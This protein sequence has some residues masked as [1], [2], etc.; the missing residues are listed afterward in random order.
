MRPS[1]LRKQATWFYINHR[2]KKGNLPEK[3]NIGITC[4]LKSRGSVY[5]LNFKYLYTMLFKNRGEAEDFEYEMKEILSTTC[6]FLER[7]NSNEKYF[8]NRIKLI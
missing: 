1:E 2:E 8:V 6:P 4:N 3:F 7:D 5:G